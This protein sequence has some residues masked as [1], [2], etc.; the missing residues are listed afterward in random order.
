M[1]SLLNYNKRVDQRKVKYFNEHVHAGQNKHEL[2]T[3][4]VSPWRARTWEEEAWTDYS[5]DT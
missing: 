2:N 3:V 1:L 4:Y 5:S